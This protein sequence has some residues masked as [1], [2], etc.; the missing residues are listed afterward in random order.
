MVP[1]RERRSS[2]A[3]RRT[4]KPA[5]R[6]STRVAGLATVNS[7]VWDEVPSVGAEPSTEV[8]VYWLPIEPDIYGLNPA[9]THTPPHVLAQPKD[10]EK[11]P[12][13]RR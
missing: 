4:T 9:Y 7:K 3:R 13:Y 6:I 1:A 11:M 2:G 10:G 5:G 12:V 8:D